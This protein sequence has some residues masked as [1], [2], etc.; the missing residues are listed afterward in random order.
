[1]RVDIF[2]CKQNHSKSAADVAILATQHCDDSISVCHFRCSFHPAFLIPR[3]V[4]AF[5]YQSENPR[6]GYILPAKKGNRKA[7]YLSSSNCA[8]FIFGF[9][10]MAC[11]K[12]SICIK[13]IGLIN[14]QRGT[15]ESAVFDAAEIIVPHLLWGNIK[16]FFLM[17]SCC[18]IASILGTT[19]L[20]S[21]LFVTIHLF[22]VLLYWLSWNVKL[23]IN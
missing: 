12:C 10:Y 8:A 19:F 6:K 11:L 4:T 21:Q 7:W 1:M 15:S 17:P 5:S 22:S 20:S 2:I 16:P 9:N 3:W 23:I 13:Q 18:S 14:G